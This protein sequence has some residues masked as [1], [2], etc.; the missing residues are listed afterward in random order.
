MKII[1]AFLSLIIIFNT[2][3]VL[4]AQSQAVIQF[5]IVDNET[6]DPIPF[7]TVKAMKGNV[8]L[9]GAISNGDGDFQIPSTYLYSIDSIVISCIGYSN[10][11]V[12]PN[13]ASENRVNEIRLKKTSVLLKE[14]VVMGRREENLTAREIVF[15]AIQHIPKN[16]PMGP[17]SYLAYY[18]D[19]QK[20]E[21]EYVNLNEA[22]VHVFDKGFRTNDFDSTKIKLYQYRLN[23]DFRTDS[24]TAIAY[25][26]TTYDR[27]KFIPGATVFPFGGNELSL[28][29][30]HD[31]IRNNKAMSYSFVDEFSLHFIRF[32]SFKLLSSVYLDEAPLYHISFQSLNNITGPDY[33][34]TGEIFIEQDNYAIHKLTYSNFLKKNSTKSPLYSID[35]EYARRDSLF[36]RNYISFNNFFRA[37]SIPPFK[38]NSIVFDNTIESFIVTFNRTPLRATALN[39]KN[40][41]FRFKEKSLKISE[42]EIA[43]LNDQEVHIKVSNSSD[44]NLLGNANLPP[45]KFTAAFKNIK[46]LQGNEV[47]KTA[48]KSVSQ[49]RELFLQNLDSHL[50]LMEK[51]PFISKDSPLNKNTIDPSDLKAVYWMNTPLKN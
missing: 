18:R 5:R 19:Y 51:G 20:E 40:Y 49:F 7:A 38:V 16:Y 8:I 15:R 43:N 44:F 50:K 31:A 42:I 48:Y 9:T 22:I 25:D 37:K 2:L 29:R 39:S 3:S 23:K 13:H 36:Y 12:K 45:A 1:N 46:D 28:L 6:G 27:N 11:V 47:N 14:I 10:R 33:V 32:H 21:N 17:F 4:N 24:S 35:V 34:A 26:T 41:D 30:I